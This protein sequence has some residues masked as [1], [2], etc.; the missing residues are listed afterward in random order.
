MSW[1]AIESCDQQRAGKVR[2]LLLHRNRLSPSSCCNW[3]CLRARITFE[4]QS[5]A[6]F[7]KCFC[8]ELIVMLMYVV[9]RSRGISAFLCH[10]LP[11][12][13]CT[14][15][16]LEPRRARERVDQCSRVRNPVEIP[17]TPLCPLSGDNCNMLPPNPEV[18][19]FCFL[20]AMTVK[21]I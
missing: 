1:F 16:N 7:Q 21:T 5:Q 11:F 13:L 6:G 18:T 12:V 2:L 8:S 3:F 17:H 9:V 20:E 15:L 19:L 14:S 10:H 4:A